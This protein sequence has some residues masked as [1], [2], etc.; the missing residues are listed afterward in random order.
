MF[1]FAPLVLVG[2]L[3]VRVLFCGLVVAGVV[4]ACVGVCI[5]A[6]SGVFVF[7]ACFGCV[8]AGCVSVFGFMC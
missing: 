4:C 7:V 1:C 8:S 5:C 6:C 3:V 2:L